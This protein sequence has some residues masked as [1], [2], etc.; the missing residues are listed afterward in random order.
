M[1]HDYCC[2]QLPRFEEEGEKAC[3]Q[4]SLSAILL[5]FLERCAVYLKGDKDKLIIYQVLLIHV[6]SVRLWILLRILKNF[7]SY[8]FTCPQIG[9]PFIIQ[10][11]ATL[12]IVSTMGLF[13]IWL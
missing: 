5:Y 9:S 3:L 11:F 12:F 8:L 13:N 4:L 1:L 7:G 2:H 10:N 6:H